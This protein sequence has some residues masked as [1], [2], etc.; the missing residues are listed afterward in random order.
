MILQ[1]V[2]GGGG[3][4]RSS[5]TKWNDYVSWDRLT[6]SLFFTGFSVPILDYLVKTLIL[7]RTFGVT[8]STS[9][10][11]LYSVMGL[12]NGI[13]LSSHNVFRGLPKGMITGNFFRSILS[14]PVAILFNSI[15]GAILMFY[16]VPFVESVLQK[17][18]AVI[19][20]AASDTVAGLIEG[21]VDRF[22]NL[23]LRKRDIGKKFLDLFETY[24]KLELLF[25][26]TEEMKILEKPEKLF[27][28]RNS[29]VRDLSVMIIINALD[30][31]YFWMYL[32]RARMTML[33]MV[34]RLT[35]EERT[36]FIQSQKILE[37]EQYISRLFV[38]GILGKN[39]SKPL[40]FYLTNY[41]NYLSG[42]QKI[43]GSGQN[44]FFCRS[45]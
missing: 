39:F 7:D 30:L 25:P 15:I 19:S 26:E 3:I 31:F 35:P 12:A 42:I 2:L 45:L 8:M 16:N 21:T 22:S 41:Q 33:D 43:K 28:S 20:K 38:D 6:D 37:H 27:I 24:T 14:I 44:P 32:P 11:L 23:D 5:L 18:A 29:E 4:N 13:Y 17:W 40:S 34:S 9:P 36:L 10:V 1:S